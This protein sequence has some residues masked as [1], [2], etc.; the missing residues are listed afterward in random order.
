MPQ[1][2][3]AT[4]SSLL[5]AADIEDH[6]EVLKAANAATKADKSDFTAKHTKVV[7]LL[8]L[9]RFDDALRLIDADGI[10]LQAIT[11]VEKAY[12]LYKT[13]KLEEADV[14]LKNAGLEKR[15]LRHIAAQVAYRAERFNDAETIYNQMLDSDP[16]N[17][18]SDLKINTVAAVAQ[19]E[20]QG[21]PSSNPVPT[22]PTS[23][24]FEV[25]Y[26]LACTEVARGNLDHAAKLLQ[27]AAILCDNSDELHDDEKQSELRPIRAQQAYVSAKLGKFSE[28]LEMYQSLGS[29]TENDGKDFVAVY[30]N[31]LLA[32]EPA[33]GN[34]YLRQRRNG[35]LVSSLDSKLFN[36]QSN[37]ITRNNLII[38]LEAQKVNGV[39]NRTN[40]I[41]N[42]AQHPNINPS[43]NAVSVLNAAAETHG[44]TGKEALRKL[45]TL[46][47]KR[48][49][50]IGLILTIIQIQIQQQQTGSALSVL[51]PFLNRLESSGDVVDQDARF[52]P[53]LVALA[54][55]L[56]RS[57][58]RE[59]SA[60]AELVKAAKYWQSRP[61]DA[62]SSLL[63][64]AGIELMRSSSVDD[65]SLAGS[66]FEKLFAEQRGSDI[67]SAGLVASFAASDASKV[68]Q[69]SAQL[70]P[71][72][73]LI[74]GVSIDDLFASGVAI[75]SNNATSR[76]RPAEETSE[77]ATKKRRRRKLPQNY[78]EGKTPDP[79]RWLPLRDRSSY[80]PK[81][82]KG[83]KKAGE[84]TQGGIVKE[85]ETLVL[86]GGGDVKVEK[87]PTTTASKKK[88]KGKK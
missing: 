48:P 34:P 83:K 19:A 42:Q 36:H 45:Q 8:K 69:H 14:V 16:A 4:L 47:A 46:A 59:S 60:K 65:L 53:G 81:G 57:Q 10:K 12:A 76:K 3:R 26:N 70:P 52:S 55:S 23:E 74:S 63:L 11:T 67:A 18:E 1:D 64:E 85:E 15:S 24:T 28:A 6:E 33:G 72:E 73:D 20:W 44:S 54:V 30:Q 35:S 32:L 31:N 29:V 43:I 5:R 79:E 78:V 39:S 49:N 77:K 27:R 9:D 56:M 75:A 68:Q 7:A 87:A 86:V 40:K 21:F 84:S 58:Q 82:K 2:P 66:A 22:Q 50:D 71:V 25:C 80:R 88:K 61:S 37:I 17:E 62:V 51:E 13:H 41:L 38:D